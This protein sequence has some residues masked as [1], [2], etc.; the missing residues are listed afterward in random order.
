MTE[1]RVSNV[2][3]YLTNIRLSSHQIGETNSAIDLL[4][5][6]GT[7]PMVAAEKWNKLYPKNCTDLNSPLCFIDVFEHDYYK[8]KIRLLEEVSYFPE[9][10]EA[11]SY[12]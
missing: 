3:H 2:Q 5:Q 6:Y 7:E 11:S 9:Y 10:K 8:G 4:K 12:L 1:F